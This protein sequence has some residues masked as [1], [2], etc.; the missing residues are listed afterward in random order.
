MHLSRG[1]STWQIQLASDSRLISIRHDNQYRE[2]RI[3][4]ADRIESPDQLTSQLCVCV[5][6]DLSCFLSLSSLTRSC[7]VSSF[8][9]GCLLFRE[10]APRLVME[11]RYRATAHPVLLTWLTRLNNLI[12]LMVQY[13]MQTSI[14]REKFSVIQT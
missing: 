8:Q 12:K 11:R 5:C 6:F 14:C 4:S 7:G 3:F 10:S 9:R 1:P 13:F 2:S